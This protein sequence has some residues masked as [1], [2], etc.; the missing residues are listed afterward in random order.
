MMKKIHVLAIVM[1][2]VVCQPV[3][4]D[5]HAMNND[6]ING[7]LE[8]TRLAK[9]VQEIDFMQKRVAAIKR[10]A[11]SDDRLH[12]N[13]RALETDLRLMRSGITQYINASLKLGRVIKP[14]RGHYSEK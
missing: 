10:Q 5:N 9:L 6:G 11:P 13:Y 12:F 14:L 2:A 8:R 4:A 7:D 1:M 3:F